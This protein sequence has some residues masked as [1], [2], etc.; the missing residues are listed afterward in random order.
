MLQLWVQ[1]VLIWRLPVQ[2][3]ILD[4]SRIYLFKLGR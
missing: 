2:L 3:L 1:R 4:E